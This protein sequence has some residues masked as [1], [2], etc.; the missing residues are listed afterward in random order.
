ME[1]GNFKSCRRMLRFPPEMRVE[2]V[3][4]VLRHFG[5]EERNRRGSHVVYCKG[6]EILV[7]VEKR[8]RKVKTTYIKRIVERLNL[9]EWYEQRKR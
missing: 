2:E 9:E 7:V 6:K 3:E 4:K 1:R 8:G 5:W